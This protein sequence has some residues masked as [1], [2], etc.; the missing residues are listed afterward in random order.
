MPHAVQA[1]QATRAPRKNTKASSSKELRQLHT[2]YNETRSRYL[3]SNLSLSVAHLL[4]SKSR[5][6]VTKIVSLG[7]GSL[8][9]STDQSRRIKQLVI[10]L[11]IASHL[12]QHHNTNIPIYAQDPTFTPTDEAFLQS[13]GVH[14]LHTP[15]AT[16][17]GEA[18]QHIDATTLVY[19]PF[20]TLEA[21]ALFFAA[22][23]LPFFVGDDFDALRLKW[24]KRSAGW[25]EADALARRFVLGLRKRVLAGGEDFWDS[26]DRPFPMAVYWRAARGEGAKARL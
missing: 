16:S 13:L 17:A 10:F 1:E 7:L 22:S 23:T 11:A 21:Y 2:L 3:G 9:R 25:S 8:L 12:Q 4:D 18:A 19:C 26:E 14:I 5:P 6:A 20:L 15:S 24:P